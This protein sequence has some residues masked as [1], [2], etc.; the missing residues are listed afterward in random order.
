MHKCVLNL[1]RSVLHESLTWSCWT[2]LIK[3]HQ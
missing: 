2:E 3:L 1:Q